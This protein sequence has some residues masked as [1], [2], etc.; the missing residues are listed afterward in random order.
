M[1]GVSVGVRVK[2][3]IFLRV[4]EMV[5]FQ[6]RFGVAVRFGTGLLLMLVLMFA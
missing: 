5:T 2:F 1:V 4:G 6:V 3:S